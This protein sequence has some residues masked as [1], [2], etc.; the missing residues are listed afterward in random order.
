MAVN[1]ER[2]MESVEV[3]QLD[4][5]GY[6]IKQILAHLQDLALSYG[7][8]AV[9]TRELEP[10]SDGATYLSVRVARPESD[11]KMA[12]RIAQEEH[13][14]EQRQAARRRQFEELQREFGK[15]GK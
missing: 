12:A 9:I 14:E 6:S 2:K 11:E 4:V 3:T 1:R 15:D 10:Y 5:D 8:D 7:E 13:W